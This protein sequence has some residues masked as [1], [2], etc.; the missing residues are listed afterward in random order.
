MTNAGAV[1]LR[2]SLPPHLEI[3]ALPN[4]SGV[5]HGATSCIPSQG[6]G[7]GDVVEEPHDVCSLVVGGTSCASNFSLWRCRLRQCT[8]ALDGVVHYVLKSARYVRCNDCIAP[9]L[10]G[11]K[12]MICRPSSSRQGGVGRGAR[13]VSERRR[14]TTVVAERAGGLVP[15]L[16]AVPAGASWRAPPV[17]CGRGALLLGA[18]GSPPGGCGL[19]GLRLEVQPAPRCPVRS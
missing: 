14:H 6:G 7:V 2:A 5:Q 4:L 3:A 1:A 16:G 15:A 8:L 10:G 13:L 18:G 9:A 12:Y 11:L 17:G 19:R